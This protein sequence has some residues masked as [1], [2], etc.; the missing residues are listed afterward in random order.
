MTYGHSTV[1]L[2][3]LGAGIEEIGGETGGATHVDE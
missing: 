3:L 1:A 2:A